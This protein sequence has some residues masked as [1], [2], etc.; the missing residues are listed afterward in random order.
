MTGDHIPLF[1]RTKVVKKSAKES[2]A[3]VEKVAQ[4]AV[5]ETEKSEILDFTEDPPF[6]TI[7]SQEAP[8]KCCGLNPSISESLPEEEADSAPKAKSDYSA[9]FL[10]LPYTLPA[11]FQVTESN[12][13]KR[14]DSFR[15]LRPLL[16]E[17]IRKDY[18]SIRDP[19]EV[20]GAVA[21]HLIKALNASY[22]L[23]CMTDLQDDAREEACEKE[24][25]L[26]LQIKELKEENKRLK[27]VATLAIKEK[28]E[29][30][31]Q[32]LAEIK[33][34]DLFQDRFNRLEGLSSAYNW[35]S[36]SS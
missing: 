3:P 10:N 16:L 32:T 13:W 19:L 27:A 12:L 25:A 21:L 8:K 26:Q 30:T 11:G 18:D 4:P 33:K 28:K 14:F 34:H 20:H 24:R 23:A 35:F 5:A 29:A 7:P 2:E 1:R 22:A 36:L 31:S 17:R 15:A 9:N 6:S